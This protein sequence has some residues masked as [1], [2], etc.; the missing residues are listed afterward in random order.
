MS[1]HPGFY[2][3][4]THQLMSLANGKVVILL[5]VCTLCSHYLLLL[6]LFFILVRENQDKGVTKRGT[7]LVFVYKI[8]KNVLF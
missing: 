8:D 6:I 3:H 2:A 7:M 5:E 4:L 1:V